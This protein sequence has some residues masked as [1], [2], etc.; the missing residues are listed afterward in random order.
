MTIKTG[1]ATRVAVKTGGIQLDGKED[2]WYNAANESAKECISKSMYMKQIEMDTDENN[3]YSSVRIV[4]QDSIE[5]KAE[6][7][8][9]GTGRDRS[10]ALSYAK[11]MAVAKINKGEPMELSTLL[12]IAKQFEEYIRTGN[13]GE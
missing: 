2:I 11:D 4:G 13:I 5:P 3:E 6:D 1:K 10:M 9:F 12:K 8:T 7:N